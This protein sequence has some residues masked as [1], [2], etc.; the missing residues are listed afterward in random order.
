MD[1]SI[2]IPV[3]NRYAD[4]QHCIASI[5][6][7]SGCLYEIIIIDDGS[8]DGDY[9][10]FAARSSGV[11]LLRTA[12]NAGPAHARNIG[13]SRAE[14]EFLL[15]LDSDTI[16]PNEHIL[17]SFLAFFATHPDAGTAG[18]E[19]RAYLKEFAYIYGQDFL[20]REEKRVIT[21]PNEPGAWGECDYLATCCCMVR[22][23]LA[24][25]VGG[26]DPYYAFGS[27]DTDFGFRIRQ[28][29]LRN[30]LAAD[31]AVEHYHS[32]SGRKPDETYRYHFTRL[33]FIIKQGSTDEI[34]FR[35]L[36]MLV[37]SVVFYLLLLPKLLWLAGNRTT[38]VKEHL[39]G[40]Y[41]MLKALM[42]CLPEYTAIRASVGRNFLEPEEM[43]R[44]EKWLQERSRP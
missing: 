42:R 34:I 10:T 4:L 25:T 15:F 23:E 28:L 27:E 7:Q 19:I 40:G 35:I 24:R 26:F 33:R 31:C 16:L 36:A 17:T 39:A 9:T 6:N 30:L 38:V 21:I 43:N 11:T 44:F 41:L 12:I 22:S 32:A 5:L 3:Y 2:I 13:I 8:S 18:G 1:I 20:E 29:G 14:G 37:G